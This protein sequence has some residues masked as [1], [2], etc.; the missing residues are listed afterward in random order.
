[1]SLKALK[2]LCEDGRIIII[3]TL[4]QPVLIEILSAT[5]TA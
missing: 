2:T 4:R 1:M 3:L 5:L